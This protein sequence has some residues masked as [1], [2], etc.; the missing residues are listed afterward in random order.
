MTAHRLT[1]L[2]Q[3]NYI[4]KMHGLLELEEIT[5]QAIISRYYSLVER[6]E[7]LRGG[8]ATVGDFNVKG[9]GDT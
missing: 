9:Y 7:D 3:H 4:H 2:N 6:G 5:R 8:K 1:E